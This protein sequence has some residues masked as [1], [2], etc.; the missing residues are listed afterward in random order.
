MVIVCIAWLFL[1]QMIVVPLLTWCQD[2]SRT[3]DIAR[4]SRSLWMIGR[5]IGEPEALLIA[6]L[7]R[8]VISAVTG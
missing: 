2:L 3:P 7:M 5:E 8:S 4:T 1:P 6:H